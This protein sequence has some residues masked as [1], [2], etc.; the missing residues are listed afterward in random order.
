ME[1]AEQL[2]PSIKHQLAASKKVQQYDI[3]SLRWFPL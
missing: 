3:Y 1:A 2:L